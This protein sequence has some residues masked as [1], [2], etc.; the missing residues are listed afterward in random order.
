MKSLLFLFI[1]IFPILPALADEC[2]FDQEHQTK[3]MTELQS[4]YKD[5]KYYK[6]ERLLEI[7][8]K[9]KVIRYQRGGC[10]HFGVKITLITNDKNDF[11]T[12][13]DIFNQV[14]K[15]TKE[16]W[17]DGVDGNDVENILRQKKWFRYGET[18]GQEVF[19]LEH[20]FA[21]VFDFVIIHKIVNEKHHISISYYMN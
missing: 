16:F 13:E 15:L 17:K 18:H 11:A 2:V 7:I 21:L 4:K 12:R 19:I 6:D 1:L 10:D 9:S 5:S 8:R 14:I 20:K 3:Y